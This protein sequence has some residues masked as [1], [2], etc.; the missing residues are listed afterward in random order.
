MRRVILLLL[1]VLVVLS[2]QPANSQTKDDFTLQVRDAERA[3]APKMSAR[4]YTAFASYVADE[5]V[6]FSGQSPTRGKAPVLAAWKS[7]FDG[8]AARFSWEPEVV[9]G[10]A[11]ARW[12]VVFDKGA[13]VCPPPT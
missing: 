3:F 5:A 10:S 6:F 11:R 13:P 2:G 7:F 12:R 8:P 1:S 9:G 4:D